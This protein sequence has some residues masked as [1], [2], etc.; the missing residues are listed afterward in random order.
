MPEPTPSKLDPTVPQ[1]WSDPSASY[2]E[3]RPWLADFRD[4]QLQALIREAQEKS[5]GLQA[6]MLRIELAQSRLKVLGVSNRP[7][8]NTSVGTSVNHSYSR[9][10]PDLGDYTQNFN[11]NF[12]ISWEA[13]L[14][15]R[16]SNQERSA[17]LS[18]EAQI[19]DQQA[20]RLALAANVAKAWFDAIETEAQLQLLQQRKANLLDRLQVVEE[21]FRLNLNS[22]LDVHLARS[23]VASQDNRIIGLRL[24]RTKVIQSLETLL[25]RTPSGQLSLPEELPDLPAMPGTG[26]PSELLQRRPDLLA[27]ERR[28]KAADQDA[29]VAYKAR[30][31]RFSL[32]SSVGT[33][34]ED[35]DKLLDLESMIWSL[36]VNLTQPLW[37]GTELEANLEQANIQTRLVALDYNRILL[38]ALQEVE[39]A[40]SAET[41]LAEQEAAI[42]RSATEARNAEDLAEEQYVSGLVSF[43]TV[44]EAQR[45][46]F[47]ARSALIQVRSDRLQNRIQLHLAL[48]GD[49]ALPAQPPASG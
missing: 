12:Q 13:D 10:T 21:S 47:D 42:R 5:P 26:L 6:A 9:L 43:V 40:L 32:N 38:N 24:Q 49:F 11:L 34:S 45:R 31:P 19:G 22:A 35:V 17:A 3:V 23:D 30:F 36:G 20:A 33:R 29:M 48:G 39:A 7:D 28:L 4:V 27:V 18:I 1:N 25:G 44:L 15:N 46:A 16:L 37:N 41:L 8:F 2:A 14:W